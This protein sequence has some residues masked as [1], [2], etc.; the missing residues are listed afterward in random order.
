[1]MKSNVSVKVFVT[2]ITE[3]GDNPYEV[4]VGGQRWQD[5]EES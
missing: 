3:Q 5:M 1:M 2:K 4:T